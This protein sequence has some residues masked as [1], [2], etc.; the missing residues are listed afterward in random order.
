MGVALVSVGVGLVI[1]STAFDAGPVTKRL[2]G[3]APVNVESASSALDFSLNNSP[4]LVRDPKDGRRLA[5]ANRVDLPGFSC[6]LH[7]SSDGGSTWSLTAIPQPRGEEPK[8]YA[9]DVAWDSEGTLYLSFVT[10]KGRGNVPNAVW[11]SRSDDGGRTLSTPT[12]L[13][14]PLSFQVRLIADPD[15]AGRLYLTWLSASE[16]SLYRFGETGNPVRAMRSDNGGR[17]WSAPAQVSGTSRARVVAPSPAVGP[18]GELYVL[19]L[20]LGD[21]QLDYEGLHEGKGGPPYDGLWQLVLARSTDRGETWGETVIEDRVVPTERFIAFVPPFPSLAVDGNSDR[22]YVSFQDGRLGD[23]DVL[24]WRSDDRGATWREPI[25]VNDTP[26]RDRTAQYLPKVA[27]AP[28]GRVDVLYYDRRED[29][30]NLENE[31]SMQSSFD[32][33]ESF[34]KH[35]RLSDRPFD[36]RVG[37]G[38]ARGLPDLGSRLGLVSASAGSFAVWTDARAGTRDAPKQD[39]ARAFVGFTEPTQL[40]APA[41]Y[42]LRLGGGA[43]VLLGLALVLGPL[44]GRLRRRT[45]DPV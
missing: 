8:C 20:D 14:G 29:P 42:A 43:L 36:S 6:G 13:L 15:A 27:V 33:G 1:V 34:A 25:R 23:A 7:V 28:N 30:G 16:V 5:V 22:V 17:E 39:L 31:V 44:R 41:R 35:L 37:F 19:Y 32:E 3:N 11:L 2:G 10:L 18:G 21:D 24:L 40:S 26:A 4:T 38:E 45:A 9:P 12:K